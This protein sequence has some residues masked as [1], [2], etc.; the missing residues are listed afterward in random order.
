[1][2][3][4]IIVAI[5]I[6]NSVGTKPKDARTGARWSKLANDIYYLIYIIKIS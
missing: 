5:K 2:N 1:M 4:V 3:T 6:L